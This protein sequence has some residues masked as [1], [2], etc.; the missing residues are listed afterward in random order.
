M[1]KEDENTA[2][3]TI[4]DNLAKHFQKTD[5]PAVVQDAKDFTSAFIDVPIEESPSKAKYYPVST[6][7]QVKSLETID[8]KNYSKMDANN[9]ASIEK[10]IDQAMDKNIRIIFPDGRGSYKDL[11]QSDRIHYL[12]LL[13][14]ATMRNWK[15][16]K[17]LVQV[18][19]HPTMKGVEK[20][21]NI[22]HKVFE[23]YS[24][25]KGIEKHYNEE[26]RCYHIYDNNGDEPIDIKIYVPTIGTINWIKNKIRELETKKYQG[27][28]V[29]YDEDFYKH[30][31]FL[32]SDWKLLSDD[33]VNKMQD[34]YDKLSVEANEVLVEAIDKINIGIKPTMKV[35]F[36]DGEEVVVPLRF[37]EYK[38]IFSI[39]DRASVLL[40]DTE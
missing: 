12:F 19:K 13:R 35:K 4:E 6:S 7:V 16:K 38:S 8:I 31:Q 33:F 14:E 2:S 40:S 24:I 30:L 32:V 37:R 27:E 28:E 3:G 23:Y 5:E 11:T 1:I 39:S 36:D 15:S 17:E 20:K 25:P 18:V 9:S 34:W 26:L 10:H 22:D 21:V 29:F